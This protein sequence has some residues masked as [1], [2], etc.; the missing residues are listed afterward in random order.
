MENVVDMPAVQAV[1]VVARAW[2]EG[3][4]LAVAVD[5]CFWRL[6]FW[7]GGTFLPATTARFRKNHE[8]R[9][10]MIVQ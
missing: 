9:L 8:N 10:E 6:N 1:V 5:V 4:M 2:G 3:C 7:R